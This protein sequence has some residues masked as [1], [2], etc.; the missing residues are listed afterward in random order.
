MT[1]GGPAGATETL[2]TFVYRIS[3]STFD[4]GYGTAIALV[5]LLVTIV[6]AIAVT[7]VLRRREVAA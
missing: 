1:G 6:L 4:F 2:S 5:L 7:T 3:F